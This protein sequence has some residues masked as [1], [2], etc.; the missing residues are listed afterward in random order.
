MNKGIPTKIE[1][2]KPN[3]IQNG[4]KNI[5]AIILSALFI[6]FY[7]HTISKFFYVCNIPIC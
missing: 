3:A 2:I 4:S 6:Y 7:L 1:H 5:V